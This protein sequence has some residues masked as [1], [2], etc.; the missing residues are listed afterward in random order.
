MTSS[1]SSK[2]MNQDSEIDTS[3]ENRNLR[4]NKSKIQEIKTRRR[5]HN[6]KNKDKADEEN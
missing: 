1:S 5:Q 2:N 6:L 3:A 4:E